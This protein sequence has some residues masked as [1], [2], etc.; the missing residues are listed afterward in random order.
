MP[1]NPLW[2]PRPTRHVT[3]ICHYSLPGKANLKD[4]AALCTVQAPPFRGLYRQE[5]SMRSPCLPAP[6]LRVPPEHPSL[7][8]C[9]P[10]SS[11]ILSLCILS[12]PTTTEPHSLGFLLLQLPSTSARHQ[13]SAV[14]CWRR[15]FMRARTCCGQSSNQHKA[16]LWRLLNK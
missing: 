10:C 13:A 5:A 2:F 16:R 4:R 7:R 15:C 9:W 14:A 8:T 12:T 3:D 11:L 6:T 1:G